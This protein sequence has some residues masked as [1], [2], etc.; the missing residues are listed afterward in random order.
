MI[1]LAAPSLVNAV[2][3]AVRVREDTPI[4]PNDIRTVSVIIP[5][6]KGREEMLA[7][8]CE[9]IPDGPEIIVVDDEDMLLAAKRNKGAAKA[10]GE[11]LLFIDD[12][13]YLDDM[14]IDRLFRAMDKRTGIMGIMACYDN[15]TDTIADGGSCRSFIS[16][17][18]YGVYTNRDKYSIEKIPYTVDE[19]ANAF[20]IKR[21]LFE[22]LGGF[23]EKNFP[24]DLDEA[25]LCKRVTNRNLDIVICPRAMCYHK[26][27][28]YSYIP[29][30]RRP[31]NAYY[32]GRN[33]ILF[34][35]KHLNLRALLV[36][37]AVFFPLFVGAYVACLLYRR[38]PIMVYYFL[39]G[40]YHGLRSRP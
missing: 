23:D 8:L 15:K 33:R 28:T 14:A 36:Y 11:Y 27:Q 26:S 1:G 9:S 6:I 32:M 22:S 38:K 5:T 4:A 30:F 13:N 2:L 7:R 12:D 18:T 19:V 35:K 24:I 16:G 3:G 29:D 31:I 39:M 20:I 37:F 10:E 21:E 40:V 34:Q 25:D 17:F